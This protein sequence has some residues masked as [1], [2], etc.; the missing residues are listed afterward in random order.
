MRPVRAIRPRGRSSGHPELLRLDF[1]SIQHD[2]K[3]VLPRRPSTRSRDVKLGDITSRGVD[4]SRRLVHKLAIRERPAH[5]ERG[6]RASPFRHDGC[7]DGVV[8][9]EVVGP[10]GYAIVRTDR[11]AKLDIGDAH[12]GGGRRRRGI[13]TGRIAVAPAARDQEG[14]HDEGNLQQ[15]HAR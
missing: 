11:P 14:D 4:R 1:L 6:I 9:T 8:R 7:V 10:V 15:L 3:P 12:G 13:A 5:G 2:L